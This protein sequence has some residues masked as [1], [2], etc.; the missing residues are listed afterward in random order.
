MFI[1]YWF[2]NLIVGH[3]F[4]FMSCYDELLWNCPETAL[5]LLWN[6]LHRRITGTSISLVWKLLWN[7][8][9]IA[10]KSIEKEHSN[11]H[12]FGLKI[13]L[14]LHWNFTWVALKLHRNCS[15]INWFSMFWKQHWKMN[16]AALKQLPNPSQKRPVENADLLQLRPTNSN[17]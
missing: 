13:A 8:S 9:E 10:L 2:V 5:K 6:Q 12:F 16:G 4:H 15:E 3:R 11:L 14:K 7:G 1:R 17:S